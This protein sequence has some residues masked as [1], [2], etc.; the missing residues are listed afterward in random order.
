MT[1]KQD[2]ARAKFKK[3]SDKAR[4]EGLKPFTKAFGKRVKQLMKK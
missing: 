1:A 2:K 4:K 3:A